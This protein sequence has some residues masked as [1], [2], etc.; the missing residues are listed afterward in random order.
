MRII[1]RIG[2][3]IESLIVGG[4]IGAVALVSG[5]LDAMVR[6]VGSLSERLDGRLA[7]LARESNARHR[8]EGRRTIDPITLK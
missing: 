1:H 6:L 4:T 3:L 8:R 2:R 5:A 7:E